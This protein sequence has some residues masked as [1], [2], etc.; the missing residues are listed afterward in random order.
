MTLLSLPSLISPVS[1]WLVD[2]QQLMLQVLR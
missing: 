2:A 1:R